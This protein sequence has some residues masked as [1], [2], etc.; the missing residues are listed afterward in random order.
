[1]V[2]KELLLISPILG[3]FELIQFVTVMA[4]PN[5]QNFLISYVIRLSILVGLRTYVDPIFKNLNY[6]LRK[7]AFW[8]ISKNIKCL[9]NLLKK[10]TISSKLFFN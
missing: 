5:L 1:M 10:F 2:L 4:A 6:F 3:A 8:S 9:S 7:L